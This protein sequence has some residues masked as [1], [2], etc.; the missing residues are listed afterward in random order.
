MS[1]RDALLEE[2]PNHQIQLFGV[3]GVS[4]DLAY[5]LP[6]PHMVLRRVQRQ[7][8]DPGGF[9]HAAGEL[10]VPLADGAARVLELSALQQP[11]AAEATEFARWA[12]PRLCCSFCPS[13]S[14]N[15][16][17]RTGSATTPSG[18]RIG[19]HG[20]ANRSDRQPANQRDQSTSRSGTDP[21]SDLTLCKVDWFHPMLA[22]CELTLHLAQV[23]CDL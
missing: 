1:L 20:I 18:S 15:L 8:V 23:G 6:E 5:G 14:V 12:D 2:E 17:T 4:E 16:R 9:L 19:R 21:E 13:W 22:S 11:G 10:L 7:V 3:R